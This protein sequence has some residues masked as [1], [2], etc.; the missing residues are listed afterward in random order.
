MKVDI[1]EHEIK[2]KLAL[3]LWEEGHAHGLIPVCKESLTPEQTRELDLIKVIWGAYRS[4]N[5]NSKNTLQDEKFLKKIEHESLEAQYI[6][7]ML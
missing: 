4:L 3:V 5:P 6:A 1:Q 2:N 7:I